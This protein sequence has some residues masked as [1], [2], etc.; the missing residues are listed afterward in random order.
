MASSHS[1]CRARRAGM[2]SV[3]G[4]GDDSPAG[5]TTQLESPSCAAAY[6][7]F[8]S[9]MNSSRVPLQKSRAFGSFSI[10]HAMPRPL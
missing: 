5:S 8:K 6:A 3:C 4:H 9:V 7:V 10:C 1:L 2:L